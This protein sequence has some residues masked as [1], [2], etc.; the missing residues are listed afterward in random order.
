MRV[1]T[2]HLSGGG[3][4]DTTLDEM[5]HESS[6]H[7]NGGLAIAEPGEREREGT[8]EKRKV[9]CQMQTGMRP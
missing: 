5:Q 3:C 8:S 9:N 2:T 4:S 6:E 1:H 7:L